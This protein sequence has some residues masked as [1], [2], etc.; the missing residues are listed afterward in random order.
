MM[1]LN[2]SKGKELVTVCKNILIKCM[3]LRQEESFLVVADET[4]ETLARS[5][6]EA[7]RAIGAETQFMLMADRSR[8]GEEPPAAIAAAMK[9]VDAAICITT[10][11]LT[12]TKAR[13]EAVKAGTRLA[14]MPGI[15]KD[16]FING[17]ITA[18][19]EKVKKLTFLVKKTLDHGEKVLIKK[20]GY[21]FSFSITGRKGI[22][23]TGVY[24]E[25]GESGNLP[26]GEA[27]IAP[28]EGSANGKLFIDGSVVGIGKLDAPMVLTVEHGKLI[29]ADGPY[30][31]QLL[32]ILGERQ[33]RM[34]AEFGIGT[35]EKA[36][37][38]GNV[39]EDEKVY[40]TVHIAFGSNL[41]FGGT[42]NAGVHIDC[43]FNSPDVFVDG[44]KV[45]DHGELTER[46]SKK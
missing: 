35:N 17:A 16:M 24:T 25:S 22:P 44:Y 21:S 23:S 26:S 31:E 36:R 19:Y 38:T 15:S 9:S 42:I 12:H 14:T 2:S 45:M 43:V 3:A 33:G 20:K 8:S 1:L 37:I 40:R 32:N 4:K 29:K 46:L 11:S 41:T 34:V 30:S 10:C 18:D 5:L 7:G 13:K 6:Y 28:V 39:L 27:F